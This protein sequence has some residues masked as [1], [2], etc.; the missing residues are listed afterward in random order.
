VS[1]THAAAQVRAALLRRGALLVEPASVRGPL[2]SAPTY[3]PQLLVADLSRS[4]IDL[5]A[6]LKGLCG[7][8]ALFVVRHLDSRLMRECVEID[9]VGVLSVPLDERQLAATLQFAAARHHLTTRE[10]RMGATLVDPAA[11]A[12]AAIPADAAEM[13]RPRERD[14]VALLLQH[15]RVPAIAEVL[16]I[17]PETVRNHLKHVFK[18][19][20]T[21]SQQHLLDWLRDA[22]SRPDEPARVVPFR[23]S[24]RP[25]PRRLQA[26]LTRGADAGGSDHAADRS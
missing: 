22:A 21:S 10:V 24:P 8:S 12:G 13:L 2:A 9:A 17:S 20:G 18:R 25:A 16:G 1:D 15:K 26:C 3:E 14:V 5:A 19:T 6:T 23:L 11:D 7:T 4:A